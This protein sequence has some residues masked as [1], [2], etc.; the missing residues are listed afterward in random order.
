MLGVAP[1]L[2]AA[3]GFGVAVVFARLGLQHMRVTTSALL[4]LVASGV[5][6]LAVAVALDSRGMLD[7]RAVTLLWLF[8]IGLLN[9]PL[10]R[11]LN[12]TAVHLAGASRAAPIVGASPLIATT[13]AISI[14]T[15]SLDPPTAMGTIAIMGG[16]AIILSQE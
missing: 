2:S 1:S 4:S 5:L 9:Y 10:G 14:G 16:I 3:L 8:L 7:L 6:T 12:Y 15:E 13:L 11:L